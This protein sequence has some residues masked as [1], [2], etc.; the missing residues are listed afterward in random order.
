VS[1]SVLFVCI[2]VLYYCHRVVTQLQLNISYHISN[3]M[4]LYTVYLYLETALYVSGVSFTHHQ[5]RMQ[6]YLQSLA[7]GNIFYIP[8]HIQLDTTLHS[9]FISG[10]YSTCF[11]CYFHPSSG[12][13]AAVSTA[14]SICQTV[15]ATCRYSGR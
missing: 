12:A 4:Q 10:K 8:I 7:F 9:L 5:E 2:C 3:K 15:T 1:F 11:G 6:L 13:H 14:S